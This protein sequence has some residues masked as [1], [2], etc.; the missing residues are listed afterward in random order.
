M[1]RMMGSLPEEIKEVS[2]RANK[3]ADNRILG[4][5]EEDRRA[6][7]RAMS[8]S[9]RGRQLPSGP[10]TFNQFQTL[11]LPGVEVPVLCLV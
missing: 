2:E 10:Y 5:A 4:F 7:Q 3:R 8:G 6:K 1:I 9:G 11:Q